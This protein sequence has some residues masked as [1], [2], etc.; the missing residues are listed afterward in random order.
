MKMDKTRKLVL[1]AIFAALIALFTFAI[2][3]KVPLP[4]TNAAYINLG[5]SVIFV[6]AY[7][8]GGH[9]AALAAAVGSALADLL[10]GSNI[11]IIGT[12][13]IKGLM[14]LIASMLL[15]KIFR[16]HWWA[17]VVV[18]LSLSGLVMVI[19]YFLYEWLILGLEIAIASVPFNL[20]QYLFGVILGTIIIRALKKY[21][22]D[23]RE[24]TEE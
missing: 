24:G 10:V 6:S 22:L 12:F 21:R 19:G 23:M 8:L 18:S 9:M 15:R 7:V 17:K 16:H 13:L 5:D 2:P 14:C 4:G 11:Y 20:I 1:G 3:F